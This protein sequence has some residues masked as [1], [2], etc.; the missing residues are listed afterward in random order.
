MPDFEMHDPAFWECRGFSLRNA[1]AL[2]QCQ[3]AYWTEQFAFYGD[4]PATWILSGRPR[5][6]AK[7]AI[8]KNWN[9]GMWRCESDIEKEA[10]LEI[11]EALNKKPREKQNPFPPEIN[12]AD[13]E[14]AAVAEAERL[15]GPEWRRV[16][17]PDFSP[18]PHFGFGPER[19][20]KNSDVFSRRWIRRYPDGPLIT[21]EKWQAMQ[22]ERR[23]AVAKERQLRELDERNRDD[24]EKALHAITNLAKRLPTTTPQAHIVSR[25]HELE[26]GSIFLSG[27]RL[28]D[29][30]MMKKYSNNTLTDLIQC[31][32]GEHVDIE[33]KIWA[34]KYLKG[35]P[36]YP[37]PVRPGIQWGPFV[38]DPRRDETLSHYCISGMPRSGKTVLIRLLIQSRFTNRLILYDDKSDMLPYVAHY[39]DVCDFLLLNPFD[40]RSAAWD[41]AKD[42]Q[43]PATRAAVAD[44]FLPDVAGGAKGKFQF[45]VA[46]VRELYIAIFECLNTLAG[47]TWDFLHFVAACCPENVRA[48]L[49]ATPKGQGIIKTDIDG[50]HKSSDDLLSYLSTMTR[51]LQPIAAAWSHASKKVS[52]RE[53]AKSGTGSVILGN[54][55]AYQGQMKELNCVLL[56]ILTDSLLDPATKSKENTLLVLDELQQFGYIQNL[57]RLLNTGASYGVTLVLG[58]HGIAALAETYGT[59]TKDILETCGHFAFLANTSTET[60]EWASRVFSNQKILVER[61]SKTEGDERT[62]V[63]EGY[64]EKER[65]IVT[66]ADIQNLSPTTK[67][68]GL[69]A[70]FKSLSHPPY[71]GHIPGTELFATTDAAKESRQAYLHARATMVND[72]PE[73]KQVRQVAIRPKLDSS[74]LLQE[75]YF[76]SSPFDALPSNKTVFPEDTFAALELLGFSRDEHNAASTPVNETSQR[77]A[78]KTIQQSD[79]S[80]GDVEQVLE[81]QSTVEDDLTDDEWENTKHLFRRSNYEDKYNWP[82]DK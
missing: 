22:D 42:V 36:H 68:A 64:T 8:R 77:S 15:H 59:A 29:P 40:A 26:D 16:T 65:P 43:T 81:P 9:A 33:T 41:I 25:L 6:R 63:T 19:P 56:G 45:G 30:A 28:A 71:R 48:I 32:M 18:T 20:S 34:D 21:D 54:N 67:T 49:A 39:D 1:I 50:Q 51:R 53:W 2:A 62:S 73:Q 24:V 35:L 55:Q 61:R 14:Q 31:G 82:D 76:D 10:W 38:L 79:E 7:A 66:R 3:V 13:A 60:A 5:L 37:K 11:G 58:I 72:R 74:Y 78:G 23:L 57:P 69:T 17:E 47:D 4:F 52:L 46:V 44:Y 12:R 75:P 80:S 70:Y 27:A